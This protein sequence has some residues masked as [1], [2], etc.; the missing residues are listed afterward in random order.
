MCLDARY[1]RFRIGVAPANAVLSG[2]RWRHETRAR[3]RNA[4]LPRNIPGDEVA[5]SECLL[6]RFICEVAWRRAAAARAIPP[7]CFR[8]EHWSVDVVGENTKQQ[9]VVIA[10]QDCARPL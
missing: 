8:V 2:G 6:V 1:K 5:F 3:R 9:A 7:F 10:G 4:G